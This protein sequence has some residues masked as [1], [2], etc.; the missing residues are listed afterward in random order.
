MLYLGLIYSSH[1]KVWDYEIHFVI[2]LR[3]I[4]VISLL[5]SDEAR[6]TSILITP[7]SKRRLNVIGLSLTHL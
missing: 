6:R 1:E 4:L 7:R 5:A 3:L 2:N